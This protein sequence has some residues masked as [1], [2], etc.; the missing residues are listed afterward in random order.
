MDFGISGKS[1]KKKFWSFG[2]RGFAPMLGV[3][4]LRLMCLLRGHA[5]VRPRP[6]LCQCFDCFIPAAVTLL[7]GLKPFSYKSMM[8]FLM[9]HHHRSKPFLTLSASFPSFSHFVNPPSSGQPPARAIALLRQK[10]PFPP[11]YLSVKVF[12]TYLL[13]P[14][15]LLPC[16]P[17]LQ[18]SKGHASKR[19]EK[20]ENKGKVGSGG[21]KLPVAA[22]SYRAA[23]LSYVSAVC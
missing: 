8:R 9:D 23:F 15:S 20:R 12:T 17:N 19:T 5:P 10:L 18:G 1:H 7:S 13:S 3:R 22:G 4:R 6:R 16:F 14:R 11:Y 21:K 2:R